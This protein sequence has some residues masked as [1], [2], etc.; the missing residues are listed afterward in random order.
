MAKDHGSK[1]GTRKVAVPDLSILSI[2]D[3]R[4][5][6]TNLGLNYS[7]TSTNTV[8]SLDDTKV[9]GQSPAAGTIVLL[10]STVSISYYTYVAPPNFFGP[11]SF[12]GPPDFFGP[13]GFFAPPSF[14]NPLAGTSCFRSAPGSGGKTCFYTSVYSCNGTCV[15]GSLDFCL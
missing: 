11:P 7:D 8:T 15:G 12:F 6:L 14:C 4:T 13:P 10:G 5:A 3:A 1:K 9:F 2:A